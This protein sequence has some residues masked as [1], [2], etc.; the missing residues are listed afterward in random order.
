MVQVFELFAGE[1]LVRHGQLDGYP[2]DNIE[3]SS[4]DASEEL[5]TDSINGD[6]RR[7]G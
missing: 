7:A 5:E 2:Y 4:N 6:F 1:Q 3:E